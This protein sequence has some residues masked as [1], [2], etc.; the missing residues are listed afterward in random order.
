MSKVERERGVAAAS[1]ATAFSHRAKLCPSPPLNLT[2]LLVADSFCQLR[3]TRTAA[4]ISYVAPTASSAVARS[5]RLLQPAVLRRV[6]AAK[7]RVKW[8]APSCS[9]SAAKPCSLRA[10]RWKE[11]W[12]AC[13]PC[14]WSA[15]SHVCY[16]QSPEWVLYAP[17]LLS[18][19]QEG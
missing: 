15:V 11:G 18:L 14:D 13:A 10:A 16:N 5:A 9:R 17:I 4:T 1:L 3:C 6:R 19:L 2:V 8:G 7:R 12:C